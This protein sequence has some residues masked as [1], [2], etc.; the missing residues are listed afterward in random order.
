MRYPQ[1]IALLR[2]NYDDGEAQAI[3]RLLA[4]KLLHISFADLLCADDM[5]IAPEVIE[6]LKGGVPIQYIIGEETFCGRDFFVGEGVLIPRPETAE[7]CQWI[8]ETVRT[9]S[10]ELALLDIGTGSGAIAVTLAAELPTAHVSAI[11]ISPQAIDFAKRNA[12]RHGVKIDFIEEDIL[13]FLSIVNSQ[14]SIVNSQQSI[15][16]SQ[17]SRHSARPSQNCSSRL[18][19]CANRSM[20]SSSS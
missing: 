17:Y 11:D 10:Q 16:N 4:D 12:K 6:K 5:N 2:E 1:L 20:P 7:L 3:A 9:S 15:V 14:Q 8:I 19:T 13:K 18:P